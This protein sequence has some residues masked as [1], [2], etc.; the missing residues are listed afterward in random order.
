LLDAYLKEDG[1]IVQE[2]MEAAFHTYMPQKLSHEIAT[3]L[4]GDIVESSVGR[5]EQFSAC[6]Y[7]HFLQYGLKLK[8]DAEYEVNSADIGTIYHEVMKRFAEFL[9][10]NGY[11]WTDFSLDEAD[12]FVDQTIQ[13]LAR[14]YENALFYSSEESLHAISDMAEVLKRSI[15]T[16]KYHMTKGLFEPKR[17]EVPFYMGEQ[18]KAKGRIDRIDT[19]EKDGEVYVK[20]V[21]YKSGKNDFD[22]VA[23]YFGLKMQ[24]AVYMKAAVLLEQNEQRDKHVIPAALVYY[25]FQNPFVEEENNEL[26]G[27]DGSV[28]KEALEE[29]IRKKM[30][31]T[32][33]VSEE[34]TVIMALDREFE[35]ESDV[36]QLKRKKDGSFYKGSMTGTRKQFDLLMDYVDYKMSE[37]EKRVYE[38]EIAVNPYRRKDKNACQY[39][40]YR[41]VCHF[42][43]RIE[44]YHMRNLDKATEEEAW[45][46]I[47]KALGKEREDGN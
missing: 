15:H 39:C 40:N 14:E 1:A 19:F 36:M 21:D 5:L 35:T 20:V 16:L 29:K 10:E 26:I 42:D 22:P 9:K 24:L 13:K 47:A 7:A 31:I 46:N 23:F 17:F 2:F 27:A 38:G 33:L 43:E 44:G 32:G 37:V 18:I 28:I 12:E 11:H 30:Q 25:Q 34:D 3:A 8:E 6:A 4:Y 45:D 41:S